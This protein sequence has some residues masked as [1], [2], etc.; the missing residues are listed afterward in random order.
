MKFQVE[1]EDTDTLGV[2]YGPRIP[3]WTSRIFQRSL[4]DH[5]ISLKSLIEEKI[6]LPIFQSKTS[7]THPLVLGD[8]IEAKLNIV[9]RRERSFSFAVTFFKE[10]IQAAVGEMVHVC[11][12]AISRE[13]KPL[14]V[15]IAEWLDAVERGDLA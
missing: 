2:I 13:K 8:T 3:V 4:A 11:I 1:L 15:P 9:D 12:D 6:H 5:G 10:D 7:I 14:P